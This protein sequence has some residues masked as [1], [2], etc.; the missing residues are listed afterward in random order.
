VECSLI[1]KPA[2]CVIRG[3][4]MLTHVRVGVYATDESAVPQPGDDACGDRQMAAAANSPKTL[5]GLE[6]TGRSFGETRVAPR[7]M[8]RSAQAF[9]LLL[10]TR[11]VL[12]TK[13]WV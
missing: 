7:T 8:R 10:T 11:S 9:L 4:W 3:F 2:G 12:T 13:W 1:S 5:E 6:C